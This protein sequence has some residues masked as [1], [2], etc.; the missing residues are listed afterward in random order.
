[1][2]KE[3]EGKHY[4]S[5]ASHPPTERAPFG[6]VVNNLN[7]AI[8]LLGPKQIEQRTR[9]SCMDNK[10]TSYFPPL[11]AVY[12]F[13]TTQ[14]GG[15]TDNSSQRTFF[16]YKM[17]LTRQSQQQNT[18]S[19]HRLLSSV[20]RNMESAADALTLPTANLSSLIILCD[21][22]LLNRQRFSLFKDEECECFTRNF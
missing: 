13:T 5:C 16:K 2:T 6:S 20:S 22:V 9:D 4:K 17:H 14:S 11:F 10:A 19:V 15:S 18:C 3:Q 7:K 8:H 1:M 21:L 12:I